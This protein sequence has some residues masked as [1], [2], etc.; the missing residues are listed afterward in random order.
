M[1]QFPS[2]LLL[3]PLIALWIPFFMPSVQAQELQFGVSAGLAHYQGDLSPDP[4]SNPIAAVLEF[5]P[6]LGVFGRW[7]QS[8]HFNLR[9]GLQYGRVTGSDATS[10]DPGRTGR[11]LSFQSDIFELSAIEEINLRKFGGRFGHKFTPYGFI[12]IAGFYFNP[13]ALYQGQLYALQPLGTEGQGMPGFP[14]RYALTQ[15]AIP[16]GGGLKFQVGQSGVLALE[17]GGRKLFTDYLDD[18]GGSYV[19]L[20]VLA[21]GNG[22]LAADLSNRSGELTG[23]EPTNYPTGTPR[24]GPAKDWYFFSTISFSWELGRQNGNGGR[25]LGCPTF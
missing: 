20:N 9:I 6:S 19:D 22:Q 13:K 5:G 18:V 3:L 1:K 8:G 10:K 15:L 12:G 7:P 17:I 23:K 25:Q 14:E 11:N 21:A 4:L 16:L 2:K 24:G